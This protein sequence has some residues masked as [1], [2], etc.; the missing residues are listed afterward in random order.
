MRARPTGESLPR[1][2]PNGE[3][4]R[5]SPAR[6]FCHTPPPQCHVLRDIVGVRGPWECH[7]LRDIVPGWCTA[8]DVTY[9]V[10]LLACG[11]RGN[12]TYYV[13]LWGV[14]AAVRGRLEGSACMGPARQDRAPALNQAQPGRPCVRWRLLRRA[15]T[16]LN[17]GNTTRKTVRSSTSSSGGAGAGRLGG[18]NCCARAAP[19]G[20]GRTRRGEGRWPGRRA[21]RAP[22]RAGSPDAS[23]RSSRRRRRPRQTCPPASS[24]LR[25]A[26]GRPPH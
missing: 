1:A 4:Q 21:G 3:R 6:L 10:T 5:S 17:R 23:G 7:V 14:S 22:A 12:V 13:T 25:P 16:G 15:G 8:E 20:G 18:H 26:A 9:Y 19:W 11:V 24:P 2:W